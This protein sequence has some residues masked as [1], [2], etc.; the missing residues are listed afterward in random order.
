MKTF[1]FR[2]ILVIGILA[3]IGIPHSDA[4]TEDQG[5]RDLAAMFD[6]NYQQYVDHFG[7]SA[8]VPLTHLGGGSA[9][10]SAPTATANRTG[11]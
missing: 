9:L 6:G 8:A 7:K 4:V 5:C 11:W 2:I 3:Y 1:L 10:R